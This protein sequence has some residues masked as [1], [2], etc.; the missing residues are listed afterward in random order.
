MLLILVI[1]VILFS[2]FP[3]LVL[4]VIGRNCSWY[5][6]SRRLT[7]YLTRYQNPTLERNIAALAAETYT[8]AYVFYKESV[9]FY[10]EKGK[11]EPS[12]ATSQTHETDMATTTSSAGNIDRATCE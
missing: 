2:L 8:R 3:S 12:P 5:L 4:V 6:V 11:P 7:R 1:L 10:K 9:C